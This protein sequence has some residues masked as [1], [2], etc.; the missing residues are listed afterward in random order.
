M[1]PEG[2]YG[3]KT[4]KNNEISMRTV[5]LRQIHIFNPKTNRIENINVPIACFFK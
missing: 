3:G 4:Q 2:M 1:L 5:A